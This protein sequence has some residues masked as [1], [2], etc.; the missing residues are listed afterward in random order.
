M[1]TALI[2]EDEPLLA[3]EI[4]EELAGVWPELQVVSMAHDG[5]E[6]WRAIE[7]LAPEVLFLD[8]Q[9]PGL[10]GLE[11]ARLAGTRAHIVFITAFDHFAVQAFDEGAVDYLVK[12]FDAAR[13]T[14]AV[15]RV[16]DRLGHVPADLRALVERVQ[17][18]AQNPSAPL[19]WITVQQGRDLRLIAI[20]DICY[21][22]ADHKYV[23]VVTT[24]SQALINTPLKDLLP[25][26]DGEV[27]WQVHRSTVVNVNA[28][29]GIV[30]ALGGRMSLV[31]KDRSESLQVSSSY[32]HLFRQW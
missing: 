8:V 24:D 22:Q 18:Q 26:L 5:H 19:R 7:S 29:H 16:K 9:M 30:H 10:N 15:R 12:P 28:V 17:L 11:L 1:T 27:F 20:D 2:A 23:T 21:F 14:R 31:L 13:L 4:L 25:R 6:A 3:A 32:A